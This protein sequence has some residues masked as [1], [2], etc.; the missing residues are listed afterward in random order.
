VTIAALD[1]FMGIF[2]LTR[3]P[4]DPELEPANPDRAQLAV[5]G[6]T[7]PEALTVT[8]RRPEPAAGHFTD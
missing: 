1:A 6:A 3:V 5:L 7:P 2:G 8:V 4:N